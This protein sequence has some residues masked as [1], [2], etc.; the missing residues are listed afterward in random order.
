MTMTLMFRDHQFRRLCMDRVFEEAKCV[1]TFTG[2][3]LLVRGGFPARSKVLKTARDCLS[4]AVLP[5]L[6]PSL[7]AWQ[8]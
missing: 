4:K 2:K 6:L 7:T 8:G 1:L 5:L 3:L